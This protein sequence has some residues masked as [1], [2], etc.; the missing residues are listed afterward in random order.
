MKDTGFHTNLIAPDERNERKTEIEIRKQ[1]LGDEI[2]VRDA[3]LDRLCAEYEEILDAEEEEE[4]LKD[5]VALYDVPRET[6]VSLDRSSKSLFFFDHIDGMYSFC[7]T[8]MGDLIHVGATTMVR[9]H[10]LDLDTPE[11]P[12][13]TPVSHA[14]ARTTGILRSTDV[15][16]GEYRTS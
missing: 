8:P 3:E 11:R 15:T 6:W 10:D 1:E 13:V 9:V 2:N 4:S 12:D 16:P 5:R 7:L 14:E